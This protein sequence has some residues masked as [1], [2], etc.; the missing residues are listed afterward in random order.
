MGATSEGR[1]AAES[2]GGWPN[3]DTDSEELIFYP[4]YPG[5]V[6]VGVARDKEMLGVG[7]RLRVPRSARGLVIAPQREV[8]GFSS[9]L[10]QV[11]QLAGESRCVAIIGPP[12]VGKNML[13]SLYSYTHG[14]QGKQPQ[15]DY[16]LA[17]SMGQ[18]PSIVH[19]A[20]VAIRELRGS[21]TPATREQALDLLLKCLRYK[22]FLIILDEFQ[23]LIDPDNDRV[24]DPS[25][26]R[27]LA[28]AANNEIGDSLIILLCR[29]E[30]VLEPRPGLRFGDFIELQ[31]MKP[32]D[33]YALLG[34]AIP[35]GRRLTR[36]QQDQIIQVTSGNPLLINALIS[37]Y[38][39]YPQPG[40]EQV[41]DHGGWRTP[42][43]KLYD[44]VRAS[45]P[46]A[47]RE[48]LEM[49]SIA[50]E[51]KWSLSES[52]LYQL[53][54]QVAALADKDRAASTLFH[55]RVLEREVKLA[56]LGLH[57]RL[58][59]GGKRDEIKVNPILAHF[60]RINV[61]P[62]DLSLYHRVMADFYNPAARK[63]EDE[64]L[65]FKDKMSMVR[66]LIKGDY[67]TEACKVLCDADVYEYTLKHTSLAAGQYV[68]LG[69]KILFAQQGDGNPTP[70]PH[71]NWRAALAYRLARVLEQLYGKKGRARAMYE[72]ARYWLEHSDKP[73]RV[74][75]DAV[76]RALG[77]VNYIQRRITGGQ[78][79][80]P[81]HPPT[82]T[83]RLTEL[84]PPN[85]RI[86][87]LIGRKKK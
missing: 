11:E 22:R 24:R 65:W 14:P 1:P 47:E 37:Q 2:K 3:H 49:L 85:R 33:V 30:F 35:G 80:P 73:D 68:E 39:D 28:A 87:N 38:Q 82:I 17:A 50:A 26:E 71:P 54:V 43:Y 41:I 19:L 52:E 77:T 48:A 10:Q 86:S 15:F 5:S 66:H 55:S 8:S 56:L 29:Q 78:V 60:M 36:S 74:L 42:L 4:Y 72:E 75:Y 12:G 79:A 53:V 20:R 13:A 81:R 84:P 45:L 25:Y 23:T 62:R 57:R 7:F 51:D 46:Q 76:M 6:R 21:V 59:A 40:L 31:A 34:N 44:Q 63:D 61:N 18:E 58:L 32:S 64:D 69:S 83:G 16:V 9:E 67:L 27:L 70:R